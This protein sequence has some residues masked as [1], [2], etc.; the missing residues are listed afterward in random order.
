MIQY[1]KQVWA[2]KE[3][4]LEGLKN[5]LFA[6]GKVRVV[7]EKR[8]KICRVCPYA[9]NNSKSPYKLPFKHCTECGCSL[10]IKPYSMESECPK[11]FWFSRK[12]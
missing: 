12:L 11:K 10:L 1:L 5:L 8:R 3:A 6:K 2:N 9:S 4:I 7:A